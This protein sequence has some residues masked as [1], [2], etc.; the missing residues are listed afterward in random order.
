MDDRIPAW[1]SRMSREDARALKTRRHL[2]ARQLKSGAGPA[3]WRFANG[4]LFA[5]RGDWFLSVRTALLWKRGAVTNL[6]VKPMAL[7]PLFWSIVGLSENAR[8]PLSFRANGAW[9]LRPL[10]EETHVALTDSEP[11]EIA[12]DVLALCADRLRNFAPPTIPAMLSEIETSPHR[13]N[14][15]ALEICL[16]LLEGDRDG[17]RALCLGRAPFDT[18]G[19]QTGDLTFF[20]QALAW[21]DATGEAAY[22]ASCSATSA[23]RRIR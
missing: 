20:D 21:I 10:G 9:V 11:G 17:G 16:R 23:G 12:A 8:L 1:P 19:F 18:G 5:Q 3:G 13:A 22:A 4:G 15:A 6:S 7:D 2:F 14:F